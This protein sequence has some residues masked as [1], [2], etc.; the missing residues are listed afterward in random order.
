MPLKLV[1]SSC[2]TVGMEVYAGVG[3]VIY[4]RD[5]LVGMFLN[6]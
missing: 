4:L 5:Q 1:V 2:S 3:L 6:L